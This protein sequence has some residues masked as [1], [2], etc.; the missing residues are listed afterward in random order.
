M[1]APVAERPWACRVIYGVAFPGLAVSDVA[2]EVL[3]YGHST[4][5]LTIPLAALGE[6]V[7]LLS[8]ES[9]PVTRSD[10]HPSNMWDG[11]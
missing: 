4:G 8:V 7:A 2:V 6:F 1:T 3:R 11:R 9:E 5:I 10:P